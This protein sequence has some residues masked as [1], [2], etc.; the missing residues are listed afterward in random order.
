[1]KKYF[2]A[3]SSPY[4]IGYRTIK[5]NPTL[6]PFEKCE[7]SLNVLAARLMGLTYANYLRFCRDCLGA[8][9]YG[10]GSRYPVAYF[11]DSKNLSVFL[12]LL[13]KRAELC[14][15]VWEDKFGKFEERLEENE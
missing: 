12:E 9:L 2:Y 1:M 13:N 8:D 14:L 4:R 7:G 3:E 10:K 5:V 15:K 11:P 6:L